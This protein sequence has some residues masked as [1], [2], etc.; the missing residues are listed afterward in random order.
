LLAGI[1]SLN[2]RKRLWFWFYGV[3]TIWALAI[4]GP[5]MALLFASLGQSAWAGQMAA[6]FDL[7]YVAELLFAKSALAFTPLLG[8]MMAVA[9]VAAIA[10]LFLLGGALQLFW[11]DEEFSMAAF[12]QGC[13]RHFWRFVR[14]ALV[15]ALFYAVV[16]ILNSLLARAGNK[17]W[18]EGSEQTPL[19]YFAWFRMALLLALCGL[20]GLI[21]DYGRIRLVAADSP[22]AFRAAGAAIR[23]VFSNFG[24]TARLYLAVWAI[25]LV[26]LAVYRGMAGIVGQASLGLVVLLFLVRQIMVLARVWVQLL[27]YSSQA[28]MYR[29]LMPIPVA[30]AP[31]PDVVET[32]APLPEASIEAPIEPEAPPTTPEPEPQPEGPPLH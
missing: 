4:V 12:F 18:D 27:F 6:N 26:L 17:I 20:V 19:V 22:K 1:R 21:F 31:V 9:L 8:A 13:G 3:T 32:L 28:E 11:S 15:Y 5:V 10:H 29:S 7:Q 24:R 16:F 30:V 2:R 14:L 25:L 23:F